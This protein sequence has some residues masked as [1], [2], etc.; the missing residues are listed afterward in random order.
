MWLQ[1]P[2]I[3]HLSIVIAR[4]APGPGQPPDLSRVMIR[5]RDRRHLEYL[6]AECPALNAEILESKDS[7]YRYR[8]IADKTAFA[9]ALHVLALGL[10][11]TNVKAEAEKHRAKVGQKFINA[12]H[13]VW[14]AFQRIQQRQD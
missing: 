6:V 7:D 9:D 8:L 3:G 14:A 11:W 10:D 4:K 2:R 13:E 1:H 12:L 5:A